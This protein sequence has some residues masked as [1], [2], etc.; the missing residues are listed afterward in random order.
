VINR[1]IDPFD[2]NPTPS[3]EPPSK[4]DYREVWL[5]WCR[6]QLD[7]AIAK[8]NTERNTRR[9]TTDQEIEHASH[10]R[11]HHPGDGRENARRQ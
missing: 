5:A 1:S 7:E 3:I 2:H 4:A 8:R 10:D 6:Q 9:R 11:N